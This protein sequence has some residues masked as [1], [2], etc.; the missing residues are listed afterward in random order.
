MRVW[1]GLDDPPKT[2]AVVSATAD[3]RSRKVRGTT[4]AIDLAI[5][6]L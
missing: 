1:F 5:K 6:A 4:L 2:H 3:R